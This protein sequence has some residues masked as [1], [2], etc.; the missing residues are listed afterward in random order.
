MGNYKISYSNRTGE[1]NQI[2]DNFPDLKKRNLVMIKEVYPFYRYWM[3]E[4]CKSE[5]YYFLYITIM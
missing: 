4:N 3:I 1:Y 5:L 2:R